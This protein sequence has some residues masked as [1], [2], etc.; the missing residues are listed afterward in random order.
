MGLRTTHS[1]RESSKA[2]SAQHFCNH[3]TLIHDGCLQEHLDV[4]T[5]LAGAPWRFTPT[6][7]RSLAALA[8]PCAIGIHKKAGRGR[9]AASTT[10]RNNTHGTP[11]CH[12]PRIAGITSSATKPRR[13]DTTAPSAPSAAA[14]ERSTIQET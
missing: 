12:C 4:Q 13:P 14:R 8:V 1:S 9:M 7:L 11:A 3:A 5:T 10:V 6:E 2:G